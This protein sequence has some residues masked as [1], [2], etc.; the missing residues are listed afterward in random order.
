MKLRWSNGHN[1][2]FEFEAND[3]G[4]FY[5]QALSAL[6]SFRIA[7]HRRVHRGEIH[8][9]V[10]WCE[11]CSL[12]VYDEESKNWLY[13]TG[14]AKRLETQLFGS[15]SINRHFDVRVPFSESDSDGDLLLDTRF[16]LICLDSASIE[17][18]RLNDRTVSDRIWNLCVGVYQHGQALNAFTMSVGDVIDKHLD[19]NMTTDD[20]LEEINKRLSAN[21]R[22]PISRR[23]LLAI[24]KY[25]HDRFAVGRQISRGTWLFAREEIDSLMPVESGHRRAK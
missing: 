6:R 12:G 20:V 19:Q 10:V 16:D 14:E 15:I 2:A 8:K 4:S 24:A 7:S 21:G 25:E 17:A 23:R 5:T 13:P 9:T 11:G 18:L 3:P 22:T 1:F